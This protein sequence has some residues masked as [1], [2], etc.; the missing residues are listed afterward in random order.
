MCSTRAREQ[1]IQK[2][3]PEREANWEPSQ[4]AAIKSTK[5]SYKI[6]TY[7][8]KD[9]KN[10]LIPCCAVQINIAKHCSTLILTVTMKHLPVLT[11]NRQIKWL[12]S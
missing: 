5:T 6:F 4:V 11:R 8:Q 1:L 7:N 3:C 2:N 12:F 9:G 10:Y